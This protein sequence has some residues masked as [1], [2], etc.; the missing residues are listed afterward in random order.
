MDVYKNSLIEN[1]EFDFK[2]VIPYF[3]NPFVYT[4]S[5]Y[6]TLMD[7]LSDKIQHLPESKNIKYTVLNL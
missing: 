1:E 3:K 4:R 5:K 6:E 2:N 7:P